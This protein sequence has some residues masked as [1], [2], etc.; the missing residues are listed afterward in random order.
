VGALEARKQFMFPGFEME[1][2]ELPAVE[3]SYYA[4]L[5]EL[6]WRA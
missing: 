1:G 3:N 6:I 2:Y 4:I 5:N